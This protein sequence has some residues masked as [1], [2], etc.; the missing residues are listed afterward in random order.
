MPWP[1]PQEIFLIQI[2]E[3]FLTMEMQSS[4]EMGHKVYFGTSTK[5][6]MKVIT[7]LFFLSYFFL[8]GGIKKV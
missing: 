1:G 5:T 8:T 3:E 2:R 6:V 4:P 7:A